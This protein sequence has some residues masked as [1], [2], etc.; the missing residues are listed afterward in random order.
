MARDEMRPGEH[1]VVD[2]TVLGRHRL[3]VDHA[4]QAR[5]PAVQ[6]GRRARQ[7]PGR[8]LLLERAGVAALDREAVLADAP[9][10]HREH[11]DQER[12]KHGDMERVE[13]QQ[14]ARPD[15]LAADEQVLQRLADHRYVVHEVGAD[16]DRPVAQLVP[17][18]QVAGER[19]GRA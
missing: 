13:A 3:A 9:D 7:G 11:R 15:L 16:R 17:R 5:T 4:E 8:R 2:R 6:V 14:R 1:R 12:R 10:V 18:Q 19:E